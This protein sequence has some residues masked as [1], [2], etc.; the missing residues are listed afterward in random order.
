[1][2]NSHFL[3][4]YFTLGLYLPRRPVRYTC[5]LVVYSEYDAV[6]VFDIVASG[7]CDRER[8]KPDIAVWKGLVAPAP[9]CSRSMSRSICPASSPLWVCRRFIRQSLRL[10][11]RLSASTCPGT[12]DEKERTNLENVD[13]LITLSRS[14]II[15]VWEPLLFFSIQRFI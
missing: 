12:L 10:H 14:Y 9:L 4:F 6:G 15:R 2:S 5:V 11:R 3:F 8:L 1:M 13:R 7:V